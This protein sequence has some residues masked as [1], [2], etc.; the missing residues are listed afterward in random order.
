L[1]EFGTLQLEWRKLSELTGDPKYAEKVDKVV[2]TMLSVDTKNWDGLFPTQYNPDTG[3]FTGGI[4][5]DFSNPISLV[6]INPLVDHITFGARGD[7]FY[8][9]LLK[10]WLL[11]YKTDDKVKIVYDKAMAGMIKKLVLKTNGGITWIAESQNGNHIQ[12]MDH[13]VRYL[14]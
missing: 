7:S 9:Y 2:D 5:D 11:T 14:D 12:K 10:Q 3:R 13:L 6:F 8:E 1:A 4:L